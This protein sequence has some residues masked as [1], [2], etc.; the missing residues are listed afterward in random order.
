MIDVPAHIQYAPELRNGAL[1]VGGSNWDLS[2]GA[3]A[4]PARALPAPT[5]ARAPVAAPVPAPKLTDYGPS[6]GLAG[7]EPVAVVTF[8][9]AGTRLARAE[10]RALCALPAGA[11]EV[12]GHAGADESA[13]TATSRA[14]AR[15]VAQALRLCG[16][17]VVNTSGFGASLKAP[18]SGALAQRRVEVFATQVRPD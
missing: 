13:A 14:R 3:A 18:E 9:K 10:R 1:S 2:R 11:Y 8:A 6:S 7:R 15:T 12:A 4:L 5:A 16:Y 17:K